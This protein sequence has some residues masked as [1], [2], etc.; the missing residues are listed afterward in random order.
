MR[1]SIALTSPP[2]SPSASS[3]LDG[4]T[5]DVGAPGA[6]DPADRVGELAHRL[7]TR[8]CDDRAPGEGDHHHEREVD[9]EHAPEA[10][11][12]FAAPVGALADLQQRAIGKADRRD[13]QCIAVIADVEDGPCL[14][15]P[16]ARRLQL[17][18]VEATPLLRH[19]EEDQ[20][21][22][23]PDGPDEERPR[24]RGEIA[25]L[26]FPRERLDAADHVRPRVLHEGGLDG[27]AVPAAE[28]RGEQDVGQGHE[29]QRARHED[30]RVPER[31]AQAERVA[32]GVTPP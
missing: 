26:D 1:S 17:R 8:P 18:E 24:R 7:Q 27:V 12:Q 11:E 4:G 19:A 20:L 15:A 9:E 28:G 32:Q 21:L 22:P 2:N 10:L 30:D 25:V 31:E 14:L 3:G 23:W 5:R 16:E 29:R 13:L 6:D